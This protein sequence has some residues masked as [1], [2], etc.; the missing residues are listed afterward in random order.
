MVITAIPGVA[1]FVFA[2]NQL[3]RGLALGATIVGVPMLAW[4]TIVDVTGTSSTNSGD[5]AEQWTAQELRRLRK[6]G[7]KVIN[8]VPLDGHDI[9]HVLVGPG[10]AYVLETKWTG[11]DWKAPYQRGLVSAAVERTTASA[12][13]LRL[14][15]HLKRLGVEPLPVVVLWGGRTNSWDETDRRRDVGGALVITGR[16]LKT[17]LREIAA[18]P[19]VLDEDAV[20]SMWK[21]LDEYVQKRDAYEQQKRPSPLSPPRLLLQA[22]LAA[23]LFMTLM[24]LA[25]V[26]FQVVEAS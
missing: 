2:D 17:W 11:K 20:A 21:A 24:L 18:L 4:S 8:H 25:G 3:L 23:L 16:A 6:L 7:W 12:R 19:R 1:V 22:C 9:D 26:L 13:R 10:G 14:W 15:H 5:Q